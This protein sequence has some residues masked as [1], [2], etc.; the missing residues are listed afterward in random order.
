MFTAILAWLIFGIELDISTFFSILV[1]SFAT[2]LYSKNPVQNL[3][4]KDKISS[5][6][7]KV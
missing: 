5:S 6:S 4:S 7:E 2:W 1:V 3:P